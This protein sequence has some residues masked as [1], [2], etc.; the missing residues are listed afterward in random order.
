MKNGFHNWR[1]SPVFGKTRLI[2]F[3][4]NKIQYKANMKQIEP[5]KCRKFQN[6]IYY[7]RWG[8]EETNNNKLPTAQL[9]ILIY[10]SFTIT[11]NNLRQEKR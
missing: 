7:A 3:K 1:I 10:M 4:V 5:I 8:K 6:N 2:P 11:C 9:L